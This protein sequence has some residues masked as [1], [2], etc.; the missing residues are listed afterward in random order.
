[1]SA[2]SSVQKLPARRM[3]RALEPY[4]AV[5][6]FAPESRAVTHELGCRG[7]WMSYFGLRAAPLGEVP[8]EVVAATF[9]NFHRD[10]VHRAIPA[11][12][13]AASPA[14][15]VAARRRSVDA[16]LRRLLGDAVESPGLVEAAGLAMEAAL[17]AP[18]AGRPLAAA[19]SALSWPA[20]PHLVLW[21]AQTL[22]RESRGD[23]HVAALVGAGLDPCE[24]LVAFAAD[25]RADAES[26][27]GYRGWSALE[28][29]EASGRLVE[30]GLLTTN[31]Q[32][33]EAGVAT[34]ERVEDR[35][36]EL[37]AVSW[38]LLGE[39]RC[40]RLV[41]LVAPLT[42][43]IV[44]NGGLASDNPMGLTPLG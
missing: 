6:Y 15:F 3:W 14:E 1:M 44:A 8:A 28:W 27:R 16:A 36:D 42:G 30:R 4:H 24:A 2:S 34:R 31:G 23:G 22:L 9:Y 21:H 25:G 33:T 10:R 39:Q 38:E 19:N 18:T 40:E 37:A 20:E 29:A 13:E 32:L 7:G 11:A 35:T 43:A 26:L 5:T 17:V 41:A 12:W